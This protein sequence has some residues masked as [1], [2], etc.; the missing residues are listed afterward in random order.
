MA[1]QEQG[2]WLCQ[3]CGGS[4][5]P[6]LAY[7]PWPGELGKRIAAAVCGN[8]W[9]E[10]VSVQTKI[11]NEYRLNVLDPGHAKAVRE[12]MEFFLGLKKPEDAAP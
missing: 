8:C 7:T 9:N 6:R 1:E 4:S 11:I 2:A 5:V 12:Q 3:R 10:W